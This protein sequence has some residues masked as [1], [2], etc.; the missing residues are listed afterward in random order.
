MGACYYSGRSLQH[1]L[2]ELLVRLDFLLFVVLHPQLSLYLLTE[3]RALKYTAGHVI[4]TGRA[5]RGH[6]RAAE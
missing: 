4:L 1:Q 5:G 3:L 2:A 6:L